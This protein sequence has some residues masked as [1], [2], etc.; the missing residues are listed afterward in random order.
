MGR[1]LSFTDVVQFVGLICGWLF[2]IYAFC[3]LNFVCL[4]FVSLS[5]EKMSPTE[6]VKKMPPPNSPPNAKRRRNEPLKTVNMRTRP[7]TPQQPG[8]PVSTVTP[9]PLMK[10]RQSLLPPK[11]VQKGDWM[12][13]WL[14]DQ[15]ADRL[16]LD[17][18]LIE[19]LRLVDWSF[20]WL[21]FASCMIDDNFHTLWYANEP[22]TQDILGL[23][24]GAGEVRMH[25]WNNCF[26]FE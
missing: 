13:D 15:L 3:F 12:I 11:A 17:D 6:E 1:S 23:G 9:R 19:W 21:R 18:R 2:A 8:G 22:P 24:K 14:I 10:P 26:F 20:G 25:A 16:R 5:E 7:G 4:R